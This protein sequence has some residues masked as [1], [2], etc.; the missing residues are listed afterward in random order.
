MPFVDA[1]RVTVNWRFW[2]RND[3]FDLP[4][5]VLAQW[6]HFRPPKTGSPNWPLA[7]TCFWLSL[8]FRFGTIQI[9]NTWIFFWKHYFCDTHKMETNYGTLRMPDLRALTREHGL[10]GYSRLR[11]ADLIAFLR[12]NLQCIPAPRPPLKPIPAPRPFEFRICFEIPY[13][14]YTNSKTPSKPIPALKSLCLLSKTYACS[15]KPMP[16]PKPSSPQSVWASTKMHQTSKTYETSSPTSWGRLVQ[17]IRIGASYQRAHRSFWINGRSR[18]DVETWKD[19]QSLPNGSRREE[20]LCCN[21]ESELI[22]QK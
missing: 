1:F 3:I 20:P 19:H 14:I 16:A 21:Q 2:C 11:K 10:R 8:H 12:D 7:W 4:K 6:C 18:M 15:Q 9:S 17:S 22:T 5:P 13:E